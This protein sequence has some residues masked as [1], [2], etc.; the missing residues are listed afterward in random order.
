[1]G[2]ILFLRGTSLK[3]FINEG[4]MSAPMGDVLLR[5]GQRILVAME[6][7]TIY[8]TLSVGSGELK[9]VAG[10]YSTSGRFFAKGERGG[11]I[12]IETERF[13]TKASLFDPSGNTQRGSIKIT[14][15]SLNDPLLLNHSVV[16]DVSGKHPGTTELLSPLPVHSSASI[17]LD[18][19]QKLSASSSLTTRDEL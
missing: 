17:Q 11:K 8:S 6:G 7:G 4:A 15:A 9:I 13:I 2:K 10:N 3:L 12:S 1:M 16:L 19:Q 18:K 5:A 14:A